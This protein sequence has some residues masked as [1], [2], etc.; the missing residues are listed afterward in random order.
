MTGIRIPF[1]LLSG[2]SA[3]AAIMYASPRA[4]RAF[5]LIELLVVI[6]II[7]ILA[8]FLL[9][10]VDRARTA[11]LRTACQS[12]LHQIGVGLAI[13]MDSND[14]YLPVIG[15]MPAEPPDGAGL[16]AGAQ[17]MVKA[18]GDDVGNLQ[19]FHCPAENK[20]Y[21][22]VQ[23]TSYAWNFFLNGPTVLNPV[24]HKAELTNNKRT[25]VLRGWR[26]RE[27]KESDLWV[28]VDSESYHGRTIVSVIENDGSEDVVRKDAEVGAYNILYMDSV[29]KPL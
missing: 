25:A 10:S 29:A 19:T 1:P 5:T 6:S 21:F 15:N 26:G 22:E 17:S 12:N 28:I 3:K 9:T 14:Q 7:A 23:G 13:Y 8:A 11:A 2:H 18:L 24:T 27:R 20:G 4:R 16:P